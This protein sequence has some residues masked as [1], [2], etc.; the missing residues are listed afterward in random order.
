MRGSGEEIFIAAFSELEDESLRRIIDDGKV[1][2]KLAKDSA[3]SCNNIDDDSSGS[4]MGSS[5]F[6]CYENVQIIP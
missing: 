4:G 6:L 1:L 5:L 3:E 2:G